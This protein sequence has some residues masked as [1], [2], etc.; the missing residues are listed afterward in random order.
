MKN[1]FNK[2]NHPLSKKE[3]VL[4]EKFSSIFWILICLVLVHLLQENSN[5]V[6]LFILSFT[7]A[8]LGGWHYDRYQKLKNN[9]S[10]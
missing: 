2:E 10:K 3:K 6:L 8:I 4:L 7:T 1:K 9:K 5:N